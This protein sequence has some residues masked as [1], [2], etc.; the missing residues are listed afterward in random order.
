M[1]HNSRL[2]EMWVVQK[3][4]VFNYAELQY[5]SGK[6]IKLAKYCA[7]RSNGVALLFVSGFHCVWE[8]CVLSEVV[9]CHFVFFDH[10]DEDERACCFTLIVS[11]L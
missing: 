10:L 7:L 9:L 4:Y 3:L 11:L 8:F 6:D 1:Y 2:V 5:V